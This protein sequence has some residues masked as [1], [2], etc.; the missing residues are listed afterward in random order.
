MGLVEVQRIKEFF[1]E[2]EIQVKYFEHKP[3]I[4]SQDAANTRGIALHQGIKAILLTNEKEF[5]VVNIPA[6]KKVDIKKVAE[7]LNWSKN[8]I[9]MATHDEVLKITGCEIGAVPPFGHKE[10]IQIFVDKQIYN[11]EENAF[12]IGLR[13]ES[14]HVPT[15]EMKKVFEDLNVKQ[16]EFAK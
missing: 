2:N 10:K 9:R 11:N 12:N 5:V 8:K 3:V 4:T 7:T 13:T 1:K 16:G 14:V 6:D 15:K